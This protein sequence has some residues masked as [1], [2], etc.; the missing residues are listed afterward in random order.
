[1]AETESPAVAPPAVAPES[2]GLFARFRAAQAV[3]V[4]LRVAGTLE[5]EAVAVTF[6][7]GTFR[8]RAEAATGSAERELTVDEMAALLG[9]LR[10]AAP[11]TTDA[12]ADLD[13][14]ALGAF[15]HVLDET[16][17]QRPATPFER[18]RFGEIVRDA[19]GSI[20]GQLAFGADVVGTVHDIGGTISFEQHPVPL[21]PS[22]FHPLSATERAALVTALERYLA[23]AR[24]APDPLWEQVLQDAKR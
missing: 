6:H 11:G 23:A 1:M 2:G 21:Q 10:D 12:G 20:L 9:V 8:V 3:V 18:A 22:S 16:L 4:T 15:V 5:G 7:E 14:T 24:P 17:R 19:A 13:P